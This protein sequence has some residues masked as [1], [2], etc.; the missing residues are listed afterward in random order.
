MQTVEIK[1]SRPTI[2]SV[3]ATSYDNLT[4]AQLYSFQCVMLFTCKARM[5][6]WACIGGPTLSQMVKWQ[7]P[8]WLLL[9]IY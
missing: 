9:L 3:L 5:P 8:F 4:C 7:K 6:D 2:V 1:S